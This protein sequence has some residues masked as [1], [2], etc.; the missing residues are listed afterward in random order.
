MAGDVALRIGARR[1]LVSAKAAVLTRMSVETSK[2][3]RLVR[4][5]GRWILEIECLVA[6]PDNVLRPMIE[7]IEGDDVILY[8]LESSPSGQVLATAASRLLRSYT[9]PHDE[10]AF[11]VRHGAWV[12]AMVGDFHDEPKLEAAPTQDVSGKRTGEVG[13]RTEMATMALAFERLSRRLT[14]SEKRQ[15]Q[16]ELPQEIAMRLD[17]LEDDNGKLRNKV[18]DLEVQVRVLLGAA[19][20][21]VREA[22]SRAVAERAGRAG[23]A[24]RDGGGMPA[25]ARGQEPSM[26]DEL[27]AKEGAAAA[28]P[29]A[30]KRR[31]VA[32]AAGPPSAVAEGAPPVEDDDDEEVDDV[33]DPEPIT[34]AKPLLFPNALEVNKAAQTLLGKEMS[35]TAAEKKGPKF[36]KK[37]ADAFYMCRLVDDAGL[38]VGALIAD[39]AATIALG[40]KLMMIPKEELDSMLASKT[41]SEDVISAMSEVFSTLSGTI[42]AVPDGLHIKV[43]PLEQLDVQA[44]SWTVKCGSRVNFVD[45]AGGSVAFVSRCAPPPVAE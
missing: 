22:A 12:P 5:N 19:T 2:P 40:G 9:D 38:E 37:G 27:T 32:P 18:G 39:L 25:L 16:G 44:V 24:V 4:H 8:H 17:E 21:D 36:N 10:R 43:N 1:R 11:E 14:E 35:L 33:P 45:G 15:M 42:N 31:E 13:M 20:E 34:P 6:L 29:E 41:P 26:P 23:G 30:T 3:K 28:I 7:R